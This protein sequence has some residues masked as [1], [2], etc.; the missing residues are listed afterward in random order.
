MNRQA[1]SIVVLLGT[2]L[3]GAGLTG[4]SVIGYAVGS[5]IDSGVSLDTAQ[6]LPRSSLAKIEAGDSIGLQL[7]EGG[8]IAGTFKSFTV[9]DRWSYHQRCLLY[10]ARL[11]PHVGIAV[12]GDSILIMG[13]SGNYPVRMIRGILARYD[14]AM[15]WRYGS[16][17][18]EIPTPYGNIDTL[19][20]SGGAKVTGAWLQEAANTETLPLPGGEVVLHVWGGDERVSLERVAAVYVRGKGDAKWIGLGIGIGV[21]VIVIVAAISAGSMSSG[22]SGGTWFK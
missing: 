15:V 16:D 20:F 12:P 8:Y 7:V 4:C 11:E 19:Y 14:T 22:G 9:E 13:H 1:I 21:D 18:D 2:V 10:N 5:A 17:G 6:V 3:T